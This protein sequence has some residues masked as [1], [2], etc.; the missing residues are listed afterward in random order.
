M[1][2][3]RL[4]LSGR[5]AERNARRSRVC[6]PLSAVLLL[7]LG[8][9]ATAT[10]SAGQL[11]SSTENAYTFLYNMMDTYAT[12]STMRLPPSYVNTNAFNVGDVGY[13][14][15][16]DVMIIALLK[17]GNTTDISRAEILGNALVYAQAHDTAGDGRVRNSYHMNPFISS[18]GALNVND[19]GSATGV[20]A[21]TGMALVQLYHSTG[22]VSYLTAA[23]SLA[24]YIQNNTYS[25]TGSGGYMAGLNAA[26]TKLT[27]K[28]TEHQIDLYSLFTMLASASGNSIYTTDATHAY[29][30]LMAMWNA[31]GGYYYIGTISD[32]VTLDI[33][34]DPTPEDI[35]TWSY[36]ATKLASHQGSIDWA[37]SNLA[38]TAGSFS[39]IEFDTG[40]HGS[41]VWF[42]GTAHMA[43][44]LR[45]RY[46]SGDATNAATLVDDLEN[47][48]SYGPNNDGEGII[49]SS[50]NGLEADGS[51]QYYSALHVGAT[52]WYCLVAEWGNPFSF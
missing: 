24:T 40:D 17:R 42:E 34:D 33:T 15:D 25:T 18:S 46:A 10:P 8:C 21:W 36:L 3:F 6:L 35:Q 41:G 7:V 27:N 22:T 52:A 48:Q 50:I 28:A 49:S 31:T 30:E 51:P 37:M 29:N 16:S 45:I 13:L 20:M 38:V 44:A 23:E 47:A 4:L 19:T 14:Y 5:R 9:G 12:G 2:R 26:G 43:A 1:N 11:A 39:G 32:G